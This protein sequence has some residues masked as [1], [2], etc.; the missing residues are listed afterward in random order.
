MKK[1]PGGAAVDYD[2]VRDSIDSGDLLMCSGDSY[3][4]K[5]IQW[6][7]DSCWSHSAFVLRVD[8]IDRVMV[9]ESVE[10]I[11][12][13]TVPL[14]N[15]LENYNGAGQAY[16]GGVVV[17]RHQEFDRKA[18]LER[19][20]GFGQFA[21]DQLGYPYDNRQIASIAAKIMSG[22]ISKRER[23]GLNIEANAYICSEYVWHCYKRLGIHIKK[24]PRGYVAP[25]D[26]AEDDNMELRYVLQR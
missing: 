20:A 13:R 26:L 4:S 5:M 19:L 9:M 10:S 11:G 21:V 16:P 8:Q 18:T 14:R 2:E 23:K 17:M 24:N 15:Y 3:F 6:A 1:F 22:L 25:S 12:V 7:T